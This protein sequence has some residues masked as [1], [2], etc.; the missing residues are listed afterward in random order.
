MGHRGRHNPLRFVGL[1][2][3]GLAMSATLGAT[4]SAAFQVARIEGRVTAGG[5]AVHNVRVTLL[6]DGY[7]PLKSLY[8]DGTG[9]FQFRVPEGAYYIEVDP[10]DKPFERQQQ[11]VDL[12]PTPFSKLG[13]LFLVEIALT[14]RASAEPKPKTNSELVF[15]QTVPD[16]AKTEYQRGMKL[17]AKK[18]DDA[19][20]AMRRALQIFPDYYAAMETLGSEYVKARYFDHALPILLHA[21]KVNPDGGK[22]YYA[23]GVLFYQ[24]QRYP[25]AVKAFTRAIGI[26]GSNVNATVYRGLSLMRDKRESEAESD[27]KKAY[28]LGVTGVPDVQLALSNI[29]VKQSRF[30]EAADELGRLLKE[31][32][33]RKDRKKIEGVITS[34][35]AKQKTQAKPPAKPS[36]TPDASAQAASAR[37]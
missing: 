29:Y 23:L 32:P 35:R 3:I 33:D 2:I 14:P 12:N 36:A 25:Y 18:P 13:E 20:A 27:F 9:R 7:S 5:K 34:L 15:Y 6:N 8:T 30:D 17:L 37:Q 19:Y 26:D 1:M 10:L 11:R 31:N 16:T 4:P 22:S 24:T 21:I 28:A